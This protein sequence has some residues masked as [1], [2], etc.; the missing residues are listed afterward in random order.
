[1][2]L[3]LQNVGYSYNGKELVLRHVNYRFEGGR[4]YAIT[5]RSGAGKTTLLSLLSQLTKP[6]EGKILY[7]GLDVSE[8]DQYLYRSQY[9]GVIFQSFNL[10]MHL[11]AVENV[12]L[13]MDIAGV[14]K[15]NNR[16]YAMELLEKVGLSKEESQRRILKLSGGQQQRVA[17]AR[18]VSYDP[19][20]LLADEPT[21][22]LDEDT[23][24]EIM[25]IFKGLAYEEQKCIIL[26]THSP[27]V[28]SLADEVYALT[29]TKKIKNRQ[30]GV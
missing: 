21:G 2:Q 13:S 7:N 15:E 5:G 28:A 18:A 11:T 29:D 10:L 14:K 8:V 30:K 17:I 16:A 23:Q 20:I 26:V 3:E 1:M 4:I 9:A 27:V 19:S 22:N 12:M 6:T 24:D 25:E